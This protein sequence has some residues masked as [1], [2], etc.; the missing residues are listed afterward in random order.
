M[1]KVILNK[2]IEQLHNT[3]SIKTDE[4]QAFLDQF[5]V[6][7]NVGI[8]SNS[9]FYVLNLNTMKYEYV[10]DACYSF[11]G[12]SSEEFREKGMHILPLIMVEEDFELLTT[13]LFPKMN[14]FSK[15]LDFEQRGK[16]VFEIYYKIKHKNSGII[17]QMVEFSS[18]TKFDGKL[19]IL[20]TG[21]CYESSQFI[22]GVK[23]IVRL[24][25]GRKQI[26][27]FEKKIIYKK[28]QL[29]KTENL[30]TALLVEGFSR[31]EIADKLSVSLHTIHTHIKNIY[32]K[33]GVNKVSELIKKV[34]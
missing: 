12:Y 19:P 14:D 3:S 23:G 6:I 24:N 10:N 26:T 18:Y 20:S 15:E 25:E 27:L 17:M 21:L 1:K 34:S 9:I 8:N 13:N 31:K 30:I 32:K 7:G 29:T 5:K 16:I 4:L 22:N 33:T 2:H 11:T 28:E